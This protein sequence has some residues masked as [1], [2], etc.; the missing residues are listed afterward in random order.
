[1]ASA[2]TTASS[3]DRRIYDLCIV[4][5]A[6]ASMGT[7]LHS[8]NDSLPEI[9]KISALTGCFSRIGIVAYRDYCGGTLTEWSGWHG[10][11][12]RANLETTAPSNKAP[13][14]QLLGFA[15]RLRP[16]YGGD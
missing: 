10:L 3:E 13:R 6:T 9:I 7:F 4:T 2:S 12:D 1:M 11:D 14:Q 8:L 16:D 5:D 15:K